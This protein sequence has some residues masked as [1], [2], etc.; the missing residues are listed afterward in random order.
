MLILLSALSL[1]MS[2]GEPVKSPKK[3]NLQ[4]DIQNVR[5]MKGDV[6]VALFNAKN[7]FPEG[8]PLEGKK[9]EVKEKSVHTTFS[10]DPGDYAI[11]VYHDENGNGKM[12]KRV[13]GIP[14][15]PY[16]FSNNFRP[17][18]SAPKFSDCQFSVGDGGKSI[19]IKLN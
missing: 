5:T 6:Y 15:E 2:G 14:K 9:L 8:K 4:V 18:M 3:A 7:A 16:G 17:T 1:F 12:D 10:V 19:S 13:F 11:A